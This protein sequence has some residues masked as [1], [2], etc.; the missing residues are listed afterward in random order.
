MTDPAGVP[1]L[2]EEPSSPGQA[3]AIETH[4]P[5]SPAELADRV[6]LEV[7][8]LDTELAEIDLLVQQASAEG[9]RHEARRAALANKIA[10][11]RG[12]ASSDPMELA[13]QNAQLVGLTRRAVVMESQV[14]VLNGK[15]KV[16]KRYRDSLAG[17]AAELRAMADDGGTVPLLTGESGPGDDDAGG[18]TSAEITRVSPAVSRMILAA[19]EDLRRDIARAMHDGPAQSLTNI[20]LQAQIVERLIASDPAA[21]RPE[22]RELIAMVQSTLDATKSFI[23]DVRPMVLDDLGLVPTVRRSA[24]DRGRRAGIP[25]D[26]DSMGT[27]R[28]LPMELESGLFRML[29]ESLAGYL[30]GSPDRVVVRLDWSPTTL[31]ALV[32]SVRDPIEA[33]TAEEIEAAESGKGGRLRGRAKPEPELPAALAAMIDERRDEQAAAHAA[34]I[35]PIALPAKAWRD[36]QARAATLGAEAELSDDGSQVRIT[37]DLPPAV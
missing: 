27:D 4:A 23:F 5:G 31:E 6:E 13:D 28:R 12:S 7:A 26:F 3:P 16:L 25:V 33:P 17:T 18:G 35:A 2:G 9:E 32:R 34:D 21:A 10:T 11:H 20:V 1:A 14:D 22:T 19:Q 29:E 8:N 30:A 24:R 37:A 15:A 36:V